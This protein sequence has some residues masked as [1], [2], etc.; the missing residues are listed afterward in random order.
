M[1]QPAPTTRANFSLGP[2]LMISFVIAL[3]LVPVGYYLSGNEVTQWKAALAI[4]KYESGDRATAV[5]ELTTVVDGS[6]DPK[7]AL[8]LI[9]WLKDAGRLDEAIERCN[10]LDV[11]EVAI[12]KADCLI[13]RGSYF[14]AMPLVLS[15]FGSDAEDSSLNPDDRNAVAY[16]RGLCQQDLDRALSNMNQVYRELSLDPRQP[17]TFRGR[18]AVA[19]GLVSR[20]TDQREYAANVISNRLRVASTELASTSGE[21][22]SRLYSLL[23]NLFPVNEQQL[24][25]ANLFRDRNEQLQ[26]EVIALKSVLA[27]L[28]DEL[29][30]T[31]GSMELRRQVSEAGVTCEKVLESLSDE[32]VCMTWLGWGAM[33]IDTRGYVLHGLGRYEEALAELDLAILAAD[34]Q[35][36]GL[37]AEFRNST[38]V[39]IDERHRKESKKA[40]ATLYNHRMMIHGSLGHS[41]RAER[42]RQRVIELGFQPGPDLF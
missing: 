16:Y 39:V 37:D 4:R 2:R 35:Y 5:E 29:G 34:I 18:V 17:M 9:E 23:R 7:L 13:L 38:M 14:D 8:V 19:A 22:N 36:E 28:L 25:N 12:K 30:Q 42:D 26:N 33:Y 1:N 24:L 40:L 31:A 41:E 20:H 10:Q 21:L 15:H 3:L 6:D 11:P 27:L 32:I